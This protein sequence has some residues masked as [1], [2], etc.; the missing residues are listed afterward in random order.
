MS[1]DAK[2]ASALA[3]YGRPMTLRRRLTSTTFND[4]TVSGVQQDY[5]PGELLGGIAQGDSR[6]TI[7]NAEI[8]A[9]AWP[10]PPKKGDFVAV[11][12]RTL[13][14]Q[15]CETKYLGTTV[16]AHVLWCRG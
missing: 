8:A 3:R 10:G 5:R 2:V 11:D 15:G 9:A 6:V 12:G 7:S 1:A 13:A 4:V 16:L 14:V